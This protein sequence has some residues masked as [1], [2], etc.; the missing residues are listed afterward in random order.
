MASIGT[1]FVIRQERRPCIVDDKRAY[2]HRWIDKEIPMVKVNALLTQK[3]LERIADKI[4][5]GLISAECGEVILQKCTLGLVE[6]EDGTVAEV[7][8]TKI[9][10]EGGL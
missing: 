4:K 6:C 2:F 9:K 10:F 5:R 8:P 3:S 7:E 1:E